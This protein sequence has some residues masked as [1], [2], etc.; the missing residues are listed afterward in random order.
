M[1]TIA[2]RLWERARRFWHA[3]ERGQSVVLLAVFLVVLLLFAGL[4]IDA[5]MIYLRRIQLSR[6]VDASAL[7][8]VVDL[9]KGVSAAD[10]RARQFMRANGVDPVML[11]QFDV[12]PSSDPTESTNVLTI[13]ATWPVQTYFMHLIGIREVPVSASA[14]AEYRSYIDMYTSQTGESGKLGPVNLSIFGPAQTPSFGDAYSCP[15]A[16][17][18][19]RGG[20]YDPRTDGGAPINE[21]HDEIPNG[22]PFRIHIPA[23]VSGVVRIE[24][25]DPECYNASNG[26][27]VEMLKTLPI[28]TTETIV[29]AKNSGTDVTHTYGAYDTNRENAFGIDRE[30][31]NPSIPEDEDPNRFWFIRMDENRRYAGNPGSY[32]NALNTTTEFRLYYIAE[33]ADGS[34]EKVHMATYIGQPDNSHNTDM[35]WDT[36]GGSA[37]QDP[38]SGVTGYNGLPASFEIDVDALPDIRLAED[39]SRSLYLEVQS[40]DGW[41]EN[42]FDLWAGPL[43]SENLAMP[44]DVNQRNVYIDRLR[45]QGVAVP[46]DSGGVVCFGSGH[47]PLNVNLSTEYVVTLAYIPPEASG[48]WVRVY[49]WDTDVGGQS[50]HYSFEG[51]PGETEGTLSGGNS[52][53]PPPEGYDRVQ[54]PE[55]Y[56]GGFLYA[57]YRVGRQDTATWRLEYEDIV[58]DAFVRLIK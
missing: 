58:G 36:P 34:I 8:S 13:D 43:T 56:V 26:S 37:P 48:I 39:G 54:V 52:W 46:H 27:T 15:K 18:G 17:V 44:A 55:H 45:A 21:Y 53:T 33:R 20:T 38:Q 35:K 16:H 42:G 25:L 2:N 40:T 47:L 22:Y 3:E 51:V 50:I 7:A 31:L 29:V 5:G 23:S 1:K 49:H 41:S 19:G 11:A 57:R 28:T 9:P 4:A 10:T 12:T 24:I 30:A 32:S 14:T 6:A